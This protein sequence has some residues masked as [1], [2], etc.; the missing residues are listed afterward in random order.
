MSK[1]YSYILGID[2]GITSIGTFLIFDNE[3]DLEKKKNP[4]LDAGVRIF[5]ESEGA[6]GRR[7]KR[8]ERKTLARRK[9]R[10]RKLRNLLRKYDLFPKNKTDEEFKLIASS[11]Y[12][13]RA[14]A[15]KEQISLYELG[16]CLIHIAKYRGAG[17]LSQAEELAEE[18]ENSKKTKSKSNPYK[19]LADEI[20][21]KKISLGEFFLN[22]LPKKGKTEENLPVR[23]RNRFLELGLINYAVP[24]F[25]VKNDFYDILKKQSEYYPQLKEIQEELED[26][27]FKDKPHAPYAIGHCSILGKEGGQSL[28]RMHPLSE[29]RRIYEEVN[30]LR[31]S[32]GRNK[33]SLSKI[34]RDELVKLAMEGENLTEARIKKNL[35]KY[36]ETI[37]KIEL[38]TEKSKKEIKGNAIVQ[39]FKNI[40]VWSDFSSE[41]QEEILN[42]IAEP[43]MS[44]E[45][46]KN[47]PLCSN[48][49]FDYLYSDEDFLKKLMEKF[50]FTTKEEEFLLAKALNKLPKDRSNLG[51]LASEKILA[52]L[53]R[54]VVSNTEAIK[55][56]GFNTHYE[57]LE[58]IKNKFD[59][60]PYYAKIL[61]QDVQAVHPWHVKTANEDEAKYGRIANPV[62]HS[63]LNQL[64]K[65]VN[66]IVELYGKPKEIRIELARDLGNSKKKRDEILRKQQANAKRNEETIK[67]LKKYNIKITGENIT[68]YKLWKE[69]QG[70]DIFTGENI[71]VTEIIKYEIEH[72]VPRSY[73][74]INA[75]I[76]LALTNPNTNRTKGDSLP[77]ECIKPE[78]YLDIQKI[79][80]SSAYP[81]RKAWRFTQ[82]AVEHYKKYN[83]ADEN[84]AGAFSDNLNTG[85]ALNDT[86]YMAR[87]ARKYL[88]AICENVNPV[89]G[90]ITAQLRHLWG[91]DYLEYELMNYDVKPL[92]NEETGETFKRAKPRLDHRHHTLDA[93]VVANTSF[94]ITQRYSRANK[95]RKGKEKITLADIGL[96]LGFES[97]EELRSALISKLKEV[98]VSIKPDHGTNGQLHDASKYGVI[99]EHP[100]EKGQHLIAYNQN[101][102]KLKIKN[103]TDIETICIGNIAN[104][105]FQK[106]PRIA[107]LYE[108]AQYILSAIQSKY[109][110]ADKELEQG[111]LTAKAEGNSPKKITEAMGV[112]K[113]INLAQND[114]LIQDTYPIVESKNLV[115][116]KPSH[117]YGYEPRAN[118]C[119]DF[120]VNSKGKI[121]WE[122]IKRFNA[123]QKNYCRE[124]QREEN[125]LLW[126]LYID[127]TFE[128]YADE[129]IV[130]KL[131]LP[132]EGRYLFKVQSMTDGKLTF[133]LLTDA[134]AKEAELNSD[135]KARLDSGSTG[136]VNFTKGEARKVELSPFGK[137]LHKHK[138]LWHG[139]KKV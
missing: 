76:N 33:I 108:K 42:F 30:N 27:I 115:Y 112:Q 84:N 89:K 100:T 9:E 44:C 90:Q 85:S 106:I 5:S 49:E 47:N 111:F 63:T 45:E 97:V 133:Y 132:C 93:F 65:V 19:I 120:Y 72:L 135:N 67:D 92:T 58:A 96:P 43:K 64:R 50:S 21:E 59:D 116:I 17:F 119:T 103:K 10:V 75:Y 138:K 31:I 88:Y 2:L 102:K 80:D 134:H 62:V 12:I 69:Q 70:K 39:A 16:R 125:K 82:E 123:N 14:K 20:Q 68:K 66:E 121:C 22:R 78:V 23:R 129:K 13:L 79:L 15:V 109:D 24:R 48:K 91:L 11:P 114:F 87:I 32:T 99:C 28:A 136:L 37:E 113:A 4:L 52:V 1:N 137:V 36:F 8:Q 105:D 95:Q 56:A 128:M 60:L 122:C 6:F 77:F 118:L 83:Q 98:K 25:L 139:T 107:K 94:S 131:N 34:M 29:E 40:S 57:N 86:R 53:K 101:L 3:E 74:G 61:T 126:S 46:V 26:A 41:K 130:N 110:E 71:E 7:L 38:N 51:K 124:S 117:N 55:L 54:E 104:P 73:N 127:D 18:D 35:K 81:E